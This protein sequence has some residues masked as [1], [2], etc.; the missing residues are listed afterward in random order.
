MQYAVIVSG[1]KQYKVSVGD[2]IEVDRLKIA[3]NNEVLFDTV[4]LHRTD[5]DISVGTPHL[6]N[7]AV[8]GK[9]L[10]NKKGEKIYVSKFKAKARH[11]R[12][13]GFRSLLSKVQIVQV[14]KEK[15]PS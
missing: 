1:G 15:L 14:G 12:R 7:V 9:V 5:N 3:E 13:I 8:K 6:A 10:E 11:R 2:I 4:L